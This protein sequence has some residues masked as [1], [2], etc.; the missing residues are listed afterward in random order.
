MKNWCKNTAFFA[1]VMVLC[2]CLAA[3]GNSDDV[4]GDDWRTNR[5]GGRQRN[6]HP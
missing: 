1:Q 5:Y 2:L 4:A 6:H 3:C